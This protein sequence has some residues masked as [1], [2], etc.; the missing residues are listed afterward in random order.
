MKEKKTVEDEEID[1]YSDLAREGKKT[2][3]DEEID[4][5]S[6]LA[7]EGKKLWKMKR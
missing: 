5:Y 7:R 6:N 4:Q 2:V 3:E 1:Q